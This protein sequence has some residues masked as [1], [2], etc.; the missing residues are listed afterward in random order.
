MDTSVQSSTP[1]V[2]N[3]SESERMNESESMDDMG[4]MMHD[5]SGEIPAGLQKAENPTYSVGDTVTIQTDHMAGMKGATGTV[6]GAF[7]T[8]A[9]E[10]D[11]R[12]NEWG[13]PSRKP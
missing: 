4:D 9:Y 7:D 8:V 2:E 10:V 5:N 11:L 13:F 3:S 1:T 6:V 12:T